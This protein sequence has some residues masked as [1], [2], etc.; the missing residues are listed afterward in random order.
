M[1]K[2]RTEVL[3][4][5][6]LELK[7]QLTGA[8]RR[9]D[10]EQHPEFQWLFITNNGHWLEVSRIGSSFQVVEYDTCPCGRLG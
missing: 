5:S 4:K 2:L 10:K 9:T 8:R 7:I 6:Q 3:S 1:A